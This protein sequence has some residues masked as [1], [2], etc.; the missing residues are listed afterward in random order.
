[1]V[2]ESPFIF[3]DAVPKEKFFDRK[4]ELDFFVSNV[5]V[6]RKMLLCIVAPLKYGKS[7][8]MQ[9]YYEILQGFPDI[10]SI[11][12]NLKK[13]KD[14]IRYI[15]TTLA[16]YGFDLEREY[17]NGLEKG[18]LLPLFDR[19]NE[20][21]V[22]TGKWLFLLFDEFHLLPEL[23]RSEGFYRD[24]SDEL[25]FGFFRGLAEGARISYVVC[26]SVIE[27]LM[28]AL[29]VWGGRFQVLYLGPFD[30]EDAVSMIKR[31]FLDGD[32][33]ISDEYARVI[34]EA[35]GYHPFYIQ[36]MGHQIYVQGK[37]N[38]ETIRN[39]KREL[40][41]FLLPIFEEYF[42]KI[43]KLE[44]DPIKTIRKIINREVLDIKEIITVAKLRRMGIIK[45]ANGD[46][47]FV[48]PL[49]ERYIESIL[50][51]YKPIDIV[52][53]GHWAERIVGNYLLRKEYI[54]YYSH[55]SRG[56]FDIYVRIHNNDVGIQVK[57]S[58]SGEIYL[59]EEDAEKIMSTAKEMRWIPILAIVSKQIKFFSKIKPGKYIIADGYADI[60]RAIES[61][62]NK[63]KSQKFQQ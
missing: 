20:L 45:P 9:R 52:V 6:K 51:G 57:Y 39:A 33:E 22:A 48:D 46:Y 61:L 31:L 42:E 54:P 25:V 3:E 58:S 37:V 13:V 56:T 23:V 40:Y 24:F 4:R 2:R 36:Y 55:D 18:D 50:A 14:P 11:Y 5:K 16:G 1:L 17:R 26:G 7:S 15:V 30:E 32:M 12:I 29:D 62:H 49:F 27:P 53:V 43:V 10:I 38:R 41:N 44:D 34:A 35:A 19:L 47:L 21:L 8:L 59:S 28:R 60:E 63:N